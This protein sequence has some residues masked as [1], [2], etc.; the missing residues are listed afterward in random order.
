MAQYYLIF[1]L[2]F[3][4]V[5]SLFFICFPIQSELP[6]RVEFFK[7]LFTLKLFFKFKEGALDSIYYPSL[8]TFFILF[9]PFLFFLKQKAQAP[10]KLFIFLNLGVAFCSAILPFFHLAL[11][12]KFSTEEDVRVFVSCISHP[13]LH[14]FLVAF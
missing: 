3:C 12:F 10:Y 5:L 9:F 1:F 6:N 11:F 14:L 8:A 13:L 7:I 4:S 2:M